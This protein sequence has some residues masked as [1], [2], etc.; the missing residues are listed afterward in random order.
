MILTACDFVVERFSGSYI[1]FDF[2][3]FSH[4]ARLHGILLRYH[5]LT[6]RYFAKLFGNL[7]D[8]ISGFRGNYSI[9]PV[10]NCAKLSQIISR[11]V[12]SNCFAI[13]Q[14]TFNDVFAPLSY[15]NSL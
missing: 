5:L 2:K 14:I 7:A 1:R 15:L 11:L 3:M 12:E 6:S 8:G 13:Q 10:C 9:Y 4:N